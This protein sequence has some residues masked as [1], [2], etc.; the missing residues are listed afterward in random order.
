[1]NELITNKTVQTANFLNEML[2]YIIKV[3]FL[4]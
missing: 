2:V 1:M 4:T 3:N